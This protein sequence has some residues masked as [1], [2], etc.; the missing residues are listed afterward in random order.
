MTLLAPDAALEEPTFLLMPERATLQEDS[1]RAREA[2]VNQA[3]HDLDTIL[4]RGIP[5]LDHRIDTMAQRDCHRRMVEFYRMRLEAALRGLQAR[6]YERD[7]RWDAKV[8]ETDEPEGLAI[9]TPAY[10]VD[11]RNITQETTQQVIW[12][13]K[14]PLTEDDR[15]A[16]RE[17]ANMREA[18]SRGDMPHYPWYTAP[19]REK[20]QRRLK[21]VG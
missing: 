4:T 11:E 2:M 13:Q 15:R 10:R 9:V 12:R 3:R 8:T 14:E 17:T 1:E 16:R 18:I 7:E 19:R 5:P 21:V 6:E 20:G